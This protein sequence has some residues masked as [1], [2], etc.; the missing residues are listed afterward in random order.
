MVEFGLLKMLKAQGVISDKEYSL[1]LEKMK[2]EEK[3]FKKA[4]A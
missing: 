1:A 3:I 2:K 4:T